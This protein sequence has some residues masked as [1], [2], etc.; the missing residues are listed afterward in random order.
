[1]NGAVRE[2]QNLRR[3][4][5][6]ETVCGGLVWLTFLSEADYTWCMRRR[7][8]IMLVNLEENSFKLII[9]SLVFHLG[10]LILY[11]KKEEDLM[12]IFKRA[13]FGLHFF[14][15]V[16]SLAHLIL[17]YVYW[18]LLSKKGVVLKNS[19]KKRIFKFSQLHKFPWSKWL[20]IW[21]LD[22]FIDSLSIPL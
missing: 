12:N 21:N 22:S 18:T 1:M 5:Q 8:R 10:S 15:V 14:M 9:T 17:F 11:Q 6:D 3:G 2:T 20:Q 7:I 13:F 4:E 16:K 19:L